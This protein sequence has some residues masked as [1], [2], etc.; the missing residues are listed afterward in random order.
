MTEDVK[1]YL[2]DAATSATRCWK[3]KDGVSHDVCFA[4]HDKKKAERITEICNSVTAP[5]SFKGVRKEDLSECF[6]V[7]LGIYAKR[8]NKKSLAIIRR[9]YGWACHDDHGLAN[10]FRHAM[11]WVGVPR[12]GTPDSLPEE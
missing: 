11:I 4:C 8:P 10:S 1:C 6:W 2:C 7:H 12:S 5:S 9:A 3:E